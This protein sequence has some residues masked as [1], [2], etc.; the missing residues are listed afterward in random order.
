MAGIHDGHRKRMR[1]R[2]KNGGL[3]GFADH[4]VLEL[5]LYYSVPQRDTNPIAHRL[6]D[7]FGTLKDVFCADIDRLTQV[8][9]ITE[10]SAVLIRMIPEIMGRAKVSESRDIPLDS[11]EKLCEFC[12]NL[13]FGESVEVAK[14]ICLDSKLRV[15]GCEDL[16]SGSN[17]KTVFNSRDAVKASFKYNA[18]IVVLCHNHP[19][20]SSRPSNADLSSTTLIKNTLSSLGI[21]LLDHIIVGS[22]SVVSLKNEGFI[23][24]I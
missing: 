6:L 1:Q 23:F 24:D 15:V 8:D 10:N 21:R 17:L 18:D 5:L 3:K 7:R 9:G 2:Y 12:K 20:G 11:A 4:E 13:F 16:G 19:G 14:I 22:D